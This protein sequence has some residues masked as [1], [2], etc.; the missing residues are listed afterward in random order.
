MPEEGVSLS[1]ANKLLTNEEVVRLARL[2][3]SQ[4]GYVVLGY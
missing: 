2:F 1:P 4:G 3:V